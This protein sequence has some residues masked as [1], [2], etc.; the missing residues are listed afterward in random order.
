MVCI[1]IHN[2]SS[3]DLNWMP[4]YLVFCGKKTAWKEIKFETINWLMGT[5][6]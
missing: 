2:L 3:F 5:E 4:A 6:K 1:Y